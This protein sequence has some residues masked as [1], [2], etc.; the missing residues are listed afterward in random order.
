[1]IMNLSSSL[2]IKVEINF[3]PESADTLPE[4][5]SPIPLAD[6]KE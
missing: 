5:G 1:M 6:G 3:T 4:M 2:P